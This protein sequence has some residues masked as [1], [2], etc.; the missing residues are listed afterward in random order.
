MNGT[1]SASGTGYTNVR[2][3]NATSFSLNGGKILTINGDANGDS[4]VLNI[5]SDTNF[6]GNVI[7]TGGLTP[8][9]VLF[10][11]VRG[12]FNLT[13]GTYLCV[14]LDN[15]GGATN[16]SQ[17]IFLDPNGTVSVD[18]SNVFG[19]VFGGDSHNFQFNGPGNLTAPLSIASPTL[20]TTP[21]PTA[22]TLGSNPVTL[23]D[24]ATLAGGNSP[25]GTI[26]F[27]LLLG[28]TKEDT[29]T[30]TVNG[31]G[32]YTTPTGYTLPG[33]GTVTG[34]YQWNASY[35]GDANNNSPVSDNGTR[36]TSR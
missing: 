21:S 1:F 19:R 10:N 23:T 32:A 27:T 9:N 18:T 5:T 12:Q 31:N 14:S 29:E 36:P 6:H 26:T 16:L 22:V 34:T 30:V 15:G 8:D 4:V 13:G 28:S 20:T 11:F 7:L 3:F 33:S 17:G 25:T 24:S 2:V 35:S